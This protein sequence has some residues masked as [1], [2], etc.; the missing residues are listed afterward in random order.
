MGVHFYAAFSDA[1]NFPNKWFTRDD[2]YYY[3]KVAQNISEGRGVTFDGINPTNGYHPLWLVLCIPIFALARFDLIL[4]L[5]ILLLVMAAL[6]AATG[7]LFYRLVARTLSE[8][9]GVLAAS[10]LTFNL[11]IHNTITQFGLETGISA[12][13]IVLLLYLLLTFEQKWRT[14]S[15]TRRQIAGLSLLAVFVLFSRLDTIFLVAVVGLWLICRGKPLRLYLLIDILLLTAAGFASFVL[16]IRLPAYY[17]YATAALVMTIV[18][19]VIKIP[20]FFFLGLYQRPRAISDAQ[21]L[22]RVTLAV[23]G[24]SLFLIAVM[25]GMG[26]TGM[27]NSFPRSS[28][29]LDWFLSLF[30]IG[31]IRLVI[32]HFEP[33][34]D[35]KKSIDPLILLKD[36]WKQ[37]LSEGGVYYGILGVTLG[38]YMLGNKLVF[39][40]FSPVSGQIKRW[41]GSLP[42]RVYGGPAQTIPAFFGLDL[43]GDFNAWVL[44]SKFI[45]SLYDT[46][47]I[48]L[49]FF[50]Y[51]TIFFAFLFVGALICLT[52]LTI[53]RRRVIRASIQLSL[54]PLFVGSVL[55]VISYNSTG[56]ASPKE[57]YWVSQII[58]TI[59][60]VS[61][62]I[63]IP[64]RALTRRFP[65]TQ[66]FIVIITTF[67]TLLMVQKYASVII[68]R[69]PHRIINTVQPYM[70]VLSLLEMNTE[71]GSLIGMT[72]GGNIG[73]L[74]HDRT[75]INMDGLINSNEYFQAMKHGQAG[76]FLER[77]GLDYVFANPYIVLK[78]APYRGQF[79]DRLE[80]ANAIYGG[81]S[82]MRFLPLG[83]ASP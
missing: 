81:K 30:L 50:D 79:T 57:W 28:L 35:A 38:S 23:T 45:Q 21:I 82:L 73:Y 75:I 60:L 58:F 44:V 33:N 69:M 6:S 24:S 62:V 40:T 11:S 12:F 7:I 13:S 78:S 32:Q 65:T 77:M 8:P 52:I 27:I 41:W 25:L 20:I 36:N 26:S 1:N 64:L 14:Q 68:D 18:G 83:P 80:V 43:D 15:I 53:N 10:F 3:F 5:R 61:L 17:Q 49:N 4:P 22:L 55:Q 19:L 42:G 66:Y 48:K 56:Y 59:L 2:A 47:L 9:V 74:I 29:I 76:L 16:R 34:K 51:K 67:V 72:G 46:I 39:G 31:T 63:D 54:L 71:P 70:D 37:W